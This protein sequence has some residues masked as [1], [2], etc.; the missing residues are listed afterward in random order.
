ME[1]VLLNSY[2]DFELTR[3]MEAIVVN[4]MKENTYMSDFNMLY[5]ANIEI[6]EEDGVQYQTSVECDDTFF[7]SIDNDF[8]NID[9]RPI[10]TIHVAGVYESDYEVMEFYPQVGEIDF[11]SNYNQNNP[12]PAGGGYLE[13]AISPF[14]VNKIEMINGEIITLYGN[15][16]A[17]VTQEMIGFK[18]YAQIPKVQKILSSGMHK[19]LKLAMY[20]RYHEFMHRK[21]TINIF[22]P[23]MRVVKEEI[24]GQLSIDNEK[25]VG[26]VR[27]NFIKDS[28]GNV[29]ALKEYKSD[30]EISAEVLPGVESNLYDIKNVISIN[31]AGYIDMS[32]VGPLLNGNFSIHFVSTINEFANTGTILF[33]MGYGLTNSGYQTH[34]ITLWIGNDGSLRYN[35]QY[36]D[37]W[38]DTGYIV[39]KGIEN[40]FT[41]TVENQKYDEVDKDEYVIFIHVNG[42]KVWPKEDMYTETEKIYIWRAMEAYRTYNEVCMTLPAPHPVSGGIDA[43]TVCAKKLLQES[44]FIT[45]ENLYSVY[46]LY[47]N[48]PTPSKADPESGFVF[49][50]DED[51]TIKKFFFGQDSERDIFDKEYYLDGSFSEITVFSP[52]LNRDEIEDLHLLNILR[53][54]SVKL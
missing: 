22:S 12:I 41:L 23:T 4:A 5:V 21:Y 16:R 40:V 39:R 2:L 52:S 6:E 10:K 34:H 53:S 32:T 42:K 45:L 29:V 48:R 17:K 11:F 44:G 15:G 28:S 47:L 33:E 18:G 25:I 14:G 20:T 27:D 38:I 49:G 31:S 54:T 24:A 43:R 1:K 36:S 37:E 30:T 13:V 3:K 8:G 46:E 19:I 9:F 26:Y 51:T 7:L 35:G 50:Q